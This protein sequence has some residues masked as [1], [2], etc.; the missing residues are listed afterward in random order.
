M[1]ELGRGGGSAWLVEDG[2]GLTLLLTHSAS[3]SLGFPGLQTGHGKFISKGRWSACLLDYRRGGTR[4]VGAAQSREER[5]TVMVDGKLGECCEALRSTVSSSDGE[6][7]GQVRELL[8]PLI[9]L[10]G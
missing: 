7:R 6:V 5:M 8:S 9:L 10:T 2:A 1:E 3:E 4:G